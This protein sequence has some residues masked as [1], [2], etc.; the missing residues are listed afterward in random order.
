MPEKDLAT[1]MAAM[2][3]KCPECTIAG[4]SLGCPKCNGTGKVYLFDDGV[5]V[6]CADGTH[7]TYDEKELGCPGWTASTDLA[8]WE[9]AIFKVWPN[10]MIATAMIA[11]HAGWVRL[12]PSGEDYGTYF[13]DRG[14]SLPALLSCVKQAV[15]EKEAHHDT[16]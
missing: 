2:E 8:V 11:T 4:M 3:E 15:L 13:S 14:E 6:S 12:F 7:S 16:R 9:Q 10:A 1:E 5:R